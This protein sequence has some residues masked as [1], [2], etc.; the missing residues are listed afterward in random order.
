MPYHLV[1]KGP[2]LRLGSSSLLGKLLTGPAQVVKAK[3]DTAALTLSKFG[4]FTAQH[5]LGG[6]PSARQ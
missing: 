6:I 4:L 3:V 5:D 2:N 1:L